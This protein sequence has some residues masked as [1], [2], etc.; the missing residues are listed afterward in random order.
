LS[1]RLLSEDMVK[2]AL[3]VESICQGC[4]SRDS[5]ECALCENRLQAKLDALD[6]G[7]RY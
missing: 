2:L 7:G 4:S 5:R 6:L 3:D 1:R